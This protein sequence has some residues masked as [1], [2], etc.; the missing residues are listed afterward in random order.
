[1]IDVIGGYS[2]IPVVETT[3]FKMIDVSSASILNSRLRTVRFNF[4]KNN[5]T[6]YLNA[7]QNVALGFKK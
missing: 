3:G 7:P 6:H 5:A 2:D 4:V 1:M